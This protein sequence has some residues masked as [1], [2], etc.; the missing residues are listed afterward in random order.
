MD[1]YMFHDWQ[2]TID[3][4]PL[5]QSSDSLLI[6]TKTRS[7]IIRIKTVAMLLIYISTELKIQSS[8]IDEHGESNTVPL[9]HD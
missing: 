9:F 6:E 8:L 5:R 2:K 1:K 3:I 7:N 4:F